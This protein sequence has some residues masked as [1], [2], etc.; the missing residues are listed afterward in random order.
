[1]H[2]HK[3]SI[4]RFSGW[5]GELHCELRRGARDAVILAEA[6]SGTEILSVS[7]L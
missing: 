3:F 6:I 4:K 7:A 5:R 1:V 2:I